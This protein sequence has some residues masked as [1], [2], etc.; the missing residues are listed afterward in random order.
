MEERLTRLEEQQALRDSEVEE[1]SRVVAEQQQEIME[2]R[3]QLEILAGRYRA[4][5]AALPEGEKGEDP[6]PPHYLPR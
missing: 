4:L 5:R 2:L 6:L 1:L 3:K